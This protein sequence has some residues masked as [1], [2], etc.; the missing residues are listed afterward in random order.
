MKILLTAFDPFGGHS[1]NPALEAVNRVRSQSDSIEIIKKVVPTVFGDSI[2][3]AAAE[4]DA[5]RP[6]AVLCV[7]LAGGSS[8]LCLERVAIN[9]DD[10]LIP[11]NQGN[12]PIDRPIVPGGPAAIFSTLPIKAMVQAIQQAGLPA[13]VSNSAGTFV[14]NH[15]MYGVLHHIQRRRLKIRAGFMHVPCT[16]EQTIHQPERPSM[17]LANITL[18]IEAAVA[19][20]AAHETDILLTGGALY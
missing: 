16:P 11:D 6:D 4:I 17:S 9:I 19:A 2:Q 14:C 8:A 5:A 20:I 12:Q 7:G 1:T 3:A 13:Q 15:L 18:G 10:A